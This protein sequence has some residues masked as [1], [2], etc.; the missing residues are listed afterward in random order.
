MQQHGLREPGLAAQV[1]R[2][3][4]LQCLGLEPQPALP[5]R[6]IS[7]ERH[8]WNA[9]V[10]VANR[11]SDQVERSQRW[12]RSALPSLIA[13]VAELAIDG[14]RGELGDQREA[15]LVLVLTDPADDLGDEGLLE[16][17]PLELLNRIAAVDQVIE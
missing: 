11:R 5:Q 7:G 8:L 14:A 1:K 16:P 10:Q 6:E 13:G 9:V 4:L 15:P 17:L 2:D 3:V 12:P